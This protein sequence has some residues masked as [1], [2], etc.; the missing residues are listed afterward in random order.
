MMYIQES[1]LSS[2]SLST[3][4]KYETTS[5]SSS[6]N[7]F[8][9]L[10]SQLLDECSA[11]KTV[12]DLVS[13][14]NQSSEKIASR[15]KSIEHLEP[16][17]VS[18]SGDFGKLRE[19]LLEPIMQD[20]LFSCAL[21]DV[22]E[23]DHYTPSLSEDDLWIQDL[24]EAMSD[25][26][27]LSL[28]DNNID[29]PTPLT[30]MQ[31][32]IVSS[33]NAYTEENKQESQI[34]PAKMNRNAS[35]KRNSPSQRPKRIYKKR[36]IIPENKEFIAEDEPGHL[37]V[38]GGRG[39]VSTHHEGNKRYWLEVLR[40]R[41]EYRACGDS[42]RDKSRIAASI[43]DYI[44]SDGG[45]FLDKDKATK[46]FFVLPDKVSLDKV[47]QALRDEYVPVWAR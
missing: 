32:R 6:L 23:R 46:R 16:L 37:D 1:N 47:K 26:P 44:K 14:L 30:A 31:P 41:E 29:R 21:D 45:R 17:R 18:D 25:V 42:N 5:F 15:P 9:L 43:V 19:L 40:R 33:G 7:S 38:V 8:G 24:R 10:G 2:Q 4:S 35:I 13:S 34:L 22:E 3:K 20:G 27:I 11:I 39:G 28:Q 36:R 12:D